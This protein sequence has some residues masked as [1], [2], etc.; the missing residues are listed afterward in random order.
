MKTMRE[1]GEVRRR[2]ECTRLIV[3]GDRLGLNPGNL[4]KLP[5]PRL[6]LPVTPRFSAMGTNQL[7]SALMI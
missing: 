1:Y 5:L 6:L 4:Y 3:G 7:S 2:E